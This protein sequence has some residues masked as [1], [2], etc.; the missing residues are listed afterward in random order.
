MVASSPV[1]PPRSVSFS[2]SLS[3]SQ[4]FNVSAEVGVSEWLSGRLELPHGA[5]KDSEHVAYSTQIYIVAEGQPN[6][7][8]LAIA[9]PTNKAR[10]RRREATTA[11]NAGLFI[12]L[13]VFF[14]F[15]RWAC[16]V[17]VNY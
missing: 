15:V 1:C 11:P 4:A 9:M 2:L 14:F 10:Q 3:L 6:A 5:I 16:R 12:R 8:E 17:Y 7:L 13:F